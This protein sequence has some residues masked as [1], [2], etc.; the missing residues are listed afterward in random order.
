MSD[1]W[2]HNYANVNG[3]R[4]HYVAQGEGPLVVLLH[5]FPEF[6]YS[7][8][9]QIPFL[10]K[11]YRVVAPDM[12]GYNETD[13]PGAGY[14]VDTLAEDIVCLIRHLGA[15]KAI[16]M[17]HDWGGGVAYHL[18]YRNP[19]VLDKLVIMNA[20]HPFHLMKALRSS[21]AQR[22]KSW[23]MFF[24][25]LPLIPEASLKANNYYVIKR[26]FSRSTVRKEA[27]TGEDI[28]KYME[29]WGKPGALNRGINYYRMAFRKGTGLW[30]FYQ[31]KKI[32][33]PT[34]IIWGEK[35]AFLGMELT[36]DLEQYSAA[37][38][39]IKHIPKCGHWVQQEAPEE[40]NRYLGEFLG[41]T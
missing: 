22:R 17:A 12:R 31:G 28:E 19:E 30:R 20:P 8:R 34:L 15:E 1:S 33:A 5:G 7:W 4:M 25:Q 40:V 14:D 21:G 16:V 39:S 9:H 13:K 6:W 35:D 37:P 38:L 32:Q 26:I 23:Y 10:A 41:I 24:F 18:A 36:R 2:T 27:F 29:A 11:K 3:I